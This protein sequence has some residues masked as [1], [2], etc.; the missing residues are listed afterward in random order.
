MLAEA[1]A[2]ILTPYA[3]IV[4]N[5]NTLSQKIKQDLRLQSAL[6]ILSKFYLWLQCHIGDLKPCLS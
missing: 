6:Q 4:S 3:I 5:M 2:V 1:Y